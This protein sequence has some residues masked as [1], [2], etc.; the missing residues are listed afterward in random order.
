M[1][2]LI[3]DDHPIF[4][5]GLR[6]TLVQLYGDICIEEAGDFNAVKRLIETEEELDL[7][8]LD[9]IFPAFDPSRDLPILRK[10]LPLTPIVI[11]SML[12]NTE[13]ISEIMNYGANGFISKSVP[14]TVM[15]DSLQ[16][17][18]EGERVVRNASADYDLQ[19][20]PQELDLLTKLSPRQV[21]VLKLI[22]RGMTNKE[23]ARELD[24]SPSTVRIHVSA[25]LKSLNVSS[26]AAAAGIAASRGL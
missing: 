24:L 18:M 14:P 2:V 8:I 4:R 10:K 23:I 11:I 7:L 19:A 1:K 15:R 20:S 26:R 3:A 17:I 12:G 16:A 5:D 22:S 13:K 21:D 6:H 9:V 25:L